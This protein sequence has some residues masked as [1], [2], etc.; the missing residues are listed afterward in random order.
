MDLN[1]ED[2]PVFSWWVPFVLRKRDRIISAVNSHVRKATHKFGIKFQ[3]Q[4][5]IALDLT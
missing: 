5:R 3:P 1:I 4:L 2:E